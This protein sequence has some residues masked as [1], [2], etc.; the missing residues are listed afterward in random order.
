MTVSKKLIDATWAEV[1]ILLTMMSLG[2]GHYEIWGV[3]YDYIHARNTTEAYNPAAPSWM[4]LEERIENDFVTDEA[5]ARMI[6]TRLLLYRIAAASSWGAQIVDDPRIEVGDIL[7]LPDNSR[8]FVTG[9][10]RDLSRGSAATLDVQ[11][12]R[13]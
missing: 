5:H 11:G 12:F 1:A 9:Y 10:S 8:L 3:P 2:T 7:Q 4:D 6:A 13:T